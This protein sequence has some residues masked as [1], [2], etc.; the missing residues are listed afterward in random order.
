MWLNK[1]PACYLV[2][3]EFNIEKLVAKD[4]QWYFFDPVVWVLDN[5]IRIQI[6]KLTKFF[7]NNK[8]FV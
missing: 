8:C 3:T 2:K 7:E 6:K 1:L 5:T 4:D